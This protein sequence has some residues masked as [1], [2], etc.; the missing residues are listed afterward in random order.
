MAIARKKEEYNKKEKGELV[1]ALE[2]KEKQLM[3][4]NMS[5]AQGK[6][7]NVR[8]SRNIRKEIAR[9]KTAIKFKSIGA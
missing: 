4:V 1:K 5:A 6:I 2:E 8:S 9:I 3:E 7:K